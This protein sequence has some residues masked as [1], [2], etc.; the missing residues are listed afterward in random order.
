PRGQ[1]GLELGERDRLGASAERAAGGVELAL[2]GVDLGPEGLDLVLLVARGLGVEGG[3]E[4]GRELRGGVCEPG[5]LVAERR[6]EVSAQARL[7]LREGIEDPALA[8]QDRGERGL[9][10]AGARR[11]VVR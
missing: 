3:A 9:E 2:E 10:R 7:G 8:T 4:A 5:E 11:Q 1:R 6:G